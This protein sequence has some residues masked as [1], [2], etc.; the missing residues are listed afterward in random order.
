M[1]QRYVKAVEYVLTYLTGYL[2]HRA[3]DDLV[4]IVLG[5]HQP[6]A[7]VSGTDASVLITGDSGTG[8]EL[9][10]EAIH[11]NSGRR[12]KKFLKVNCAAFNDNLLESEMFGYEAGAFTGANKQTKGK[13]EE[14]LQKGVMDT[15]T[16]LVLTNAIYFKGSW[17]DCFDSQRTRPAPFQIS[18]DR[19]VTVP[20]M[21]QSGP[22]RYGDG[23]CLRGR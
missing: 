10:A 17:A 22:F 13:I 16:R 9:V 12:D 18:S 4:L 14:L 19:T 7:R 1:G 3:R 15:L 21:H 8:K 5:D 2:E 11:R 23:D 20:M 6:A